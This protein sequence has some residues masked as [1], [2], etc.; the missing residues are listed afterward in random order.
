ML[1]RRIVIFAI[2]VS[3]VL[4]ECSLLKVKST[5]KNSLPVSGDLEEKVIYLTFDDGPSMYTADLLDLLDKYEVKVTFFV[6][7]Q[8]PEYQ[9]LIGEAYRRGHTIGLHSY[10]HNYNIYSCEETYYEDLALMN[11]VI[12]QQTGTAATIIR[13]PGGSSNSVSWN[14]CCGIMS[15]LTKGVEERGYTYCDWNVDSL[16]SHGYLS[17]YEIAQTA[18]CGIKNREVSIVLMHDIGKCNIE[19][20]EKII[21]WGLD[22]GYIFLPMQEDMEMVHHKTIN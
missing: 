8:Y 15:R 20:A 14:Y 3:L 6:T 22:N 10:S 11:E 4:M 5:E 18:I 16:D 13:F 9:N 12:V 7:N 17:A 2:L 1:K 19:A 21:C